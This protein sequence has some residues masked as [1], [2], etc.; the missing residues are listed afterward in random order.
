MKKSILALLGALICTLGISYGAHAKTIDLTSEGCPNGGLVV[1]QGESTEIILSGKTT[2]RIVNNGTAV[3]KGNGAI[4]SGKSAPTITNNGTLTINGGSINK[5][6]KH[7]SVAPIVNNGTLTINGGSITADHGILHNSGTLTMNGGK[8]RAW[9]HPAIWANNSANVR[10]NGGT[11]H[12]PQDWVGIHTAGN[13]AICGGTFIGGSRTNLSTAEETK[14]CPAEKSTLETPKQAPAKQI[15][16]LIK[17]ENDTE[18]KAAKAAQAAAQTKTETVV[19]TTTKA[20]KKSEPIIVVITQ[21]RTTD[22]LVKNNASNSATTKDVTDKAVEVKETK[23]ADE[24]EQ[25]TNLGFAVAAILFVIIA[26]ST[27][28]IVTRRK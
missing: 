21:P 19:A 15:A 3:I 20:T 28:I 10:V 24:E 4:D 9:L 8:I 2:C 27:G 14:T 13:V 11:L 5:A 25:Q 1:A 23:K 26:A 22:H 7:D 18:M 12:F 6:A 16:G 17:V